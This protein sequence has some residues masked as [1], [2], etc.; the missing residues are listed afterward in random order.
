MKAIYGATA[1][2]EDREESSVRRS[3]QQQI[4]SSVELRRCAIPS[5]Q[6]FCWLRTLRARRGRAGAEADVAEEVDARWKDPSSDAG[7]SQIIAEDPRSGLF[8]TAKSAFAVD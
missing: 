8:L 4:G 7:R 5:S 2:E 6:A 3:M 1:T